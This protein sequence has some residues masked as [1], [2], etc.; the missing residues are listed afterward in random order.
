VVRGQRVIHLP[1]Q[2]L[3][4]GRPSSPRRTQKPWVPKKIGVVRDLLMSVDAH[5][6]TISGLDIPRSVSRWVDA[7][8][9]RSLAG[10][11]TR[12]GGL[13]SDRTTSTGPGCPIG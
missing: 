1:A 3:D 9:M 6:V 10:P 4:L 12:P 5:L 13:L 8:G 11:G 2:A 7:A